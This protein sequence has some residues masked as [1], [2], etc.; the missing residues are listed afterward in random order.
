MPR[1]PHRFRSGRRPLRAAL[2]AP[3][4]AAGLAGAAEPGG[5]GSGARGGE[6]GGPGT[7]APPGVPPAIRAL[8]ETRGLP[9]ALETLQ[10]SAVALLRPSGCAPSWRT[11]VEGAFDPGAVL[12]ATIR[13]L[14]SRWEP[15]HAA[16]AEELL[17]S[18]PGR[19]LRQAEAWMRATFRPP[20]QGAPRPAAAASRDGEE[21]RAELLERLARASA[22]PATAAAVRV[23]IKEALQGACGGLEAES[24]NQ[25]GL[26]AT[27]R[28]LDREQTRRRL[29]E[30]FLSAAARAYEPLSEEELRRWVEAMESP[31]ARWLAEALRESLLAALEERARRLAPSPL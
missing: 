5:S 10:E 14:A 12:G 29:E 2:L 27:L 11:P 4:L 22:I 25:R 13:Q 30:A 26:L 21:S 28:R 9:G 17:A 1:R 18:D 16:A 20:E 3:A 6:P 7:E 23:G 31:A 24:P 8:L 15:E 19:R